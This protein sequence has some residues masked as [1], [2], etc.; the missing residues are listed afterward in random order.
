MTD[1]PNRTDRFVDDLH[2]VESAST[3]RNA[4]W[5]RLGAAAMGIGLI[6]AVVGLVLSQST[7]NPLDQSTDLSLGLTGLALCIVGGVVFLR[8]SLTQFLRFWLFRFS[9]ETENRR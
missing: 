9:H 2:S 1:V 6:L 3:S 5:V 4:L 8:Y 7:D